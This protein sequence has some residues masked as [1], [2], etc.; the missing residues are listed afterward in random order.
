MAMILLCDVAQ[1]ERG[2]RGQA[3]EHEEDLLESSE[4]RSPSRGSRPR[5]KLP[6]TGHVTTEILSLGSGL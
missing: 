5:A 6:E 4:A 3:R 1:D 2:D